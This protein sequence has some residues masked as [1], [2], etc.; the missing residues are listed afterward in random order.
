MKRLLVVFA[1]CVLVGGQFIGTV[2]AVEYGGV[3]GRPANPQADNPRSKSIFIYTLKAGQ[4]ANDGVRVI[5]NTP[6]TRNIKVYAVDAVLASGGTFSCAQAVESPKGVGS[7]VKLASSVVTVKPNSNVTVPFTVTVPAK[8]DVG[9]HD[10]CIAIQDAS[11][12]NTS[13]KSGVV[14]SFRSAIRMAVTVPGKIVKKLNVL[15][16]TTQ[17]GSNNTVVITPTVRNDGNVSLDTVVRSS[18]RPLVGGSTTDTTGSYP[19]LP[20]STAS[21]NLEIKRPFWGGLYRATVSATFNSD[22]ASSLGSKKGAQATVR[23][24]SQLLFV[25]PAPLALVVE[26]LVLLAIILVLAWV[27][28]RRWQHRHVRTRWGAYTAKE[29]DT[30]TAVAASHHV[31]WKQLARANKLRAPYHL[32]AGQRLRVPPTTKE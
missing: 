25:A 31:S 27:V 3:G 13:D 19:I 10:G 15:S 24:S 18:L 30:L 8:V 26:L 12:S 22:P 23:K 28:R 32:E 1:F 2:G 17:S 16:V 21:W 11:Q 20:R 4:S 7:W 9:E 14:L 29:G 6:K 5:N